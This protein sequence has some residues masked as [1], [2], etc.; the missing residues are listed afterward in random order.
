MTLLEQLEGRS[1]AMKVA[2]VADL[3]ALHPV[4]V[5]RLASEGRIPSVR[6]AGAVRFDPGAI[7]EYLKKNEVTA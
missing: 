1:K 7:A 2:E 5:Y 6:V 3:L 4:T